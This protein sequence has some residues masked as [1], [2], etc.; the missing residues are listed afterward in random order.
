MEGDFSVHENGPSGLK[1]RSCSPQAFRQIHG[2]EGKRLEVIPIHFHQPKS[3]SLSLQIP[4]S[5]TTSLSLPISITSPY[6]FLS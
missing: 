6:Y 1:Y 4:S 2:S 3:F 5:E